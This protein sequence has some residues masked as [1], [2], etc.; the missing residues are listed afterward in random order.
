MKKLKNLIDQVIKSV[1]NFTLDNV[2]LKEDVVFNKIPKEMQTKAVEYALN[3][4]KKTANDVVNEFK[5][6]DPIEIAQRSGVKITYTAQDYAVGHFIR[7]SEYLQKP[8]T[9]FLYETTLSQINQLIIKHQLHQILQIKDVA[10]IYV[11]HELF[12]HIEET[13]IKPVS[14]KFEVCTF[15][16]GP[17]SIKSGISSL[18]EIAA[19]N[20]TKTLLNLKFS[21]KMLDYLVLFIYDEK[22]AY[23]KLTGLTSFPS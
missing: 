13:K 3:L 10:P 22:Q 9:I 17:F 16:L 15:K 19:N 4:G 12:H 7:C 1:D 6:R 11:A 18:S 21:P 23:Q 14:K 20:F 2:M 8:P 5:I